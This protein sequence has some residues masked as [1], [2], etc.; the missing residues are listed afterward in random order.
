MVKKNTLRIAHQ[1]HVHLTLYLLPDKYEVL[2]PL[3]WNLEKGIIEQ[4]FQLR[5]IYTLKIKPF[6]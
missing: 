6:V 1:N 2:V 5:K 3:V 4:G